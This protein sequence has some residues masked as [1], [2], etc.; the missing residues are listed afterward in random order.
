MPACATAVDDGDAP[1]NSRD[2]ELAALQQ[3]L[4]GANLA[5]VKRFT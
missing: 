2:I 1:A 4:D 3:L 5:T